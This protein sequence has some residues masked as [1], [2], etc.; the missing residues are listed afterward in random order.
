MLWNPWR[1]C[2]RCSEGCKYCYIHKGDQRKKI[3]TD[4]IVKTKDFAKPIKLNDKNEYLMRTN[5][6]VYVCFS[7][8]FLIN[9]ADQWR[10]ECYQMMRERSDLNFLFLTKRIERFLTI[11]PNDWGQGYDNITVG[12]SVENQQNADHRLKI[13]N[14]LPIKHKNIICQP[15]IGP[16]DLSDHLDDVEL[17]VVGGESDRNGRILNYDWV[18]NLKNQCLNKHVSFSFRQCASNF[19]KDDNYYHIPTK[20]LISQAKKA[21]IDHYF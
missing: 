13:L 20:Q 1:G 7:S 10:L 16:I 5:K 14:S 3:D 21:G 12:V 11:L 8:D 18:L 19:I 2:H 15:M 9:E 17:V 4:I 6:I